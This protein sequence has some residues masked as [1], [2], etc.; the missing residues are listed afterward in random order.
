[1]WMIFPESGLK[2]HK[3]LQTIR[4]QARV[5]AGQCTLDFYRHFS[6]EYSLSREVFFSHPLLQRLREDVLPFIS[7]GSGHGIEH[8][9][10]VS[11]DAGTLALIES[12][13][14]TDL[15]QARRLCLLAQIAGLLHDI[16]RHEENHASRGAELSLIILKDYPL[17][18]E[19]QRDTAFAVRN[20][21]AF[22]DVLPPGNQRQELLSDV[23]YDADKFRWGPDNFVTTLWEICSCEQWSMEEI[24][25]RFPV[26]LEHIQKIQETFRTPTGRIYGPEFIHCGL[27]IGRQ[28]YR[29]LKAHLREAVEQ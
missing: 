1:M 7:Q 18:G 4:D 16:S 20:H 10:K 22:R 2:M 8:S 27:E 13:L 29:I 21:E 26:G 5:M 25:N 17:S 11:I 19:E 6:R 23:L 14:W 9:K 28:V 24:V 3:D 12:R 15:Q